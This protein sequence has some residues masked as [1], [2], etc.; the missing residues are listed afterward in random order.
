MWY[1]GAFERPRGGAVPTSAP[2]LG[3]EMRRRPRGGDKRS[4]RMTRRAR[5]E[6]ASGFTVLLVDDNADYLQATRLLLEREGHT[7]L[8]ATNGVEALGIL[9]TQHVDLLLLDYF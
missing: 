5:V 6:T 1:L 7:V 9:P 2:P 3:H 8:T 4:W